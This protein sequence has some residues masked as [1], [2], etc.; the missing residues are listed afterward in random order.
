MRRIMLPSGL[1]ITRIVTGLWQVADQERHGGPLE[2]NASAEA[3]ADY[4]AAG[5][6]AFDMADHYG[7]A[8]LIAGRAI[9]RIAERGIPQR[10]VVMTKW[11]PEPGP[12]TAEVTRQAVDQSL[13]RLGLEQI[14]L[15]QL[16]WWDFQ[17]PGYLDAIAELE[18]LRREGKIRF[19]GVTNFDTDH[20]RL[21]VKNGASITSNQVSF[22]IL[23]QRAAGDM[24][25]LCTA[26]GIGLF[27]YGS[28]AGG[29]LSERW[30]GASE[31]A[32]AGIDDWSKM[33]YKRFI[34]AIGGWPIVQKILNALKSVAAKHQVSI[35]N[36]ATRWV[37]EQPAVAAVIIGARLGEREHRDDNLR[38]FRFSLDPED[39]TELAAACADARPIP[40]DCGD[41]YRRPPYLTASGDLSHHLSSFAKVFSPQPIEA[42]ADRQRIDTGSV[43]EGL[44]GYSRAVRIGERIVVSGT[45]A[46]H[47]NSGIVCRGDVQGQT[48]YI[49]DKIGASISAL[50]GTLQDVVRTRIYLRDARQWEAAARVHGRYFAGIF[51][52]NTLV[53]VGNLVGDYDVEIEA[54]AVIAR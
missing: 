1:E 26:E 23:D 14:E 3:L 20:L 37:L 30:I 49:L 52:A 9:K 54:E 19:I 44:S 29:L 4:A 28:L 12:M 7:S 11:C 42:H 53:E 13:Q 18:A 46:T 38:V 32:A 33:K 36:I 51:P 25:S 40:G 47:G 41:E 17:H 39:H 8:E 5:F 50:G 6:V 22:S 31:A 34:E 27:A 43:W 48:I 21:I 15:M 24:T 10:P 16:H 2:L 35:A 45:T